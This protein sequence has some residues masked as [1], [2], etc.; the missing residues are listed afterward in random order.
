MKLATFDPRVFNK[1]LIGFDRILD[2]LNSADFGSQ[3]SNFPPYNVVKVGVDRF[4]IQIAAAGFAKEDINI[5]FHKTRLI[6]TGHKVKKVA[7]SDSELS[8]ED[9]DVQYLHRGIAERDFKKVFTLA[10]HVEVTDAEMLNGILLIKL[11]RVVP[12][13]KKPKLIEIK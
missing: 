6:V 8:F 10:E 7:D 11:T 3:N 12:E 5:E 2:E 9:D 4:E 13:D 1:A